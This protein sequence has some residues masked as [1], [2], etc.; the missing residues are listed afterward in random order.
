MLNVRMEGA[1]RFGSVRG[2][3]R[4][5]HRDARG[6]AR[7]ARCARESLRTRR[8]GGGCPG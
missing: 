5:M 1:M 2:R 8:D 7:V 4:V 3:R 6:D